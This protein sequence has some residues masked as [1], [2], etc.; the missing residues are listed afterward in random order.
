M[1]WLN[2]GLSIVKERIISGTSLMKLDINTNPL[3]DALAIAK[4]NKNAISSCKGL[5]SDSQNILEM[6]RVLRNQ[7]KT[8]VDKRL[9]LQK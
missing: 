1:F 8:E 4:I 3:S 9:T 2:K 6:V 5:V 7:W